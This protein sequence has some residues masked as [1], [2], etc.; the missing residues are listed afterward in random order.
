MT[1][2][3]KFQAHRWRREEGPPDH[4][5]HQHGAGAESVSQVS[6]G[7]LK[8]RVGQSERGED[9]AHLLLAEAKVLGDEGRRLGNAD[10]IDI[11]NHR[12]SDCEDNHQM[13]DTRRGLG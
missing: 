2:E 4:D 8:Q 1:M 6:A 11:G 12:Q 7:D 13:S 9:I 5:P 3:A 10:P